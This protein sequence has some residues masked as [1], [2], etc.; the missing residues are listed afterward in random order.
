MP[1]PLV[2]PLCETYGMDVWQFKRGQPPELPGGIFGKSC[3][4]I[5]DW[6]EITYHFLVWG[7]LY[8]EGNYTNQ[9][10]I[11][12]SDGESMVCFEGT[13]DWRK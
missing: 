5:D 4:P 2:L 3:P 6:V 9:I 10:R 8:D 11:L 7:R 1:R 12:D 13:V